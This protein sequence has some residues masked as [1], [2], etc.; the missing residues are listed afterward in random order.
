LIAALIGSGASRLSFHLESTRY[1][2][3]VASLARQAGVVVGVALNPITPISSIEAL[4]PSVDFVN[5]LTTDPD[6]FGEQLLPGM[7]D[8]VAAARALLPEATALEVDGGV[9]AGNIAELRAAG[10]D[11]Y[12]VGRAVCGAT[13]WAAALGTLRA[14]ASG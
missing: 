4:G 11:E 8:R 2:W 7:P 1:P 13:D 14:A 10:A 3:R 12:A 9:D 5:L 6:L